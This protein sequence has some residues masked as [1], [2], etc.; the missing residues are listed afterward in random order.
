MILTKSDDGDSDDDGDDD[1]DDGDDDDKDLRF[2]APQQRAASQSLRAYPW[3][4]HL[5]FCV[6]DSIV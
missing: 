3:H 5:G 1:G 2:R 4:C 6:P